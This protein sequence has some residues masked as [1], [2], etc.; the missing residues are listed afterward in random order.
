VSIRPGVFGN[1]RMQPILFVLPAAAIGSLFAI[2]TLM[3]R[4][5]EWASF[6]AS[7]IFLAAMLSGAAAA[8]YPVL[9]PAIND[10]SLSVTV[11]NAAAGRHALTVGL[12]WWTFGI[13]LA[14]VYVVFVYRT[15]RGKVS[16]MNMAQ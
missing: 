14:V 9:L 4:R 6:I 11:F 12:V 8:L 15:F 3:R 1:F 7:S 13:L 5:R 10:P 2:R 16:P